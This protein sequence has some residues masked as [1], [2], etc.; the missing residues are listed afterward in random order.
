MPLTHPLY[1]NDTEIK[2]RFH[3]TEEQPV[4]IAIE[5]LDSEKGNWLSP[6]RLEVV[7]QATQ[8][9]ATTPGIQKVMS[10]S[11]IEAAMV[12]GK[13]LVVGNIF[14]LL[15]AA[16]WQERINTD[17]LLK[18]GLLS[19]DSRITA[20]IGEIKV[21]STEVAGVMIRSIRQAMASRFPKD[22]FRISVTGVVSLQADMTSLIEIEM[23]N[24]L[25]F[26][27]LTCF[28]T[29]IAYFRSFSSVVVCLILVVISNIGALSWMAIQGYSFSVLSTS[30]PILASITA[31]AIGSHTLLDFSANCSLISVKASVADKLK[32]LNSTYRAL[33]LPNFLMAI[34][35]VIGF[36][37]LAR[38]EIPLI[39]EFAW[40]V[41]GGILISWFLITV[42]LPPLL[43]LCPVPIS[44]SW[45]AKKAQ[46]IVPVL[47]YR[48]WILGCLIFIV[49]GLTWRGLP[50][51]WSVHLYDDL[52][53]YGEI[54]RSADL[55]DQRMGG[56]FPLEVLIEER[57]GPAP[58]NDPIR[59][60]AM[61]DALSRIRKL[62]GVGSAIGYADFFKFAGSKKLNRQSIAETAFLYSMT[63]TKDPLRQFL[64]SD[65]TAV[66]MSLRLQDISSD[67]MRNT[68]ESVN[69]IVRSSFPLAIVKLG[70][71]AT[72]AHQLNAELSRT[73]IMGLWESLF[74]IT[75]LI[76]VVFRSFRLA[77]VSALP[78]LMAPL[79][80]TAAMSFLQTPIKPIVGVIFSI[81][82]GL[83]YN[84]TVYLVV[85]LK[86]VNND[87]KR[88]WYEEGNPC[89]CSSMAMLGGFVVFL[90]SYFAINRSFG[91]YMLWS[92]TNGLLGDL[93][94]FPILLFIFPS[95]L[96]HSKI[97]IFLEN[98][99]RVLFRM[100]FQNKQMI[101]VPVKYF[102]LRKFFAEKE[103][104]P[105]IVRAR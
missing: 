67:K 89:L 25:A 13:D 77:L 88:A 58:W 38:S 102:Y 3:L 70:G 43:V 37:T 81:A 65:G 20:I 90:F 34:T 68:V 74:W 30:V 14:S 105:L 11:T 46:W 31:L 95:I 56:M 29:L 35:T 71:M 101:Q 17:P 52:P 94:L 12:Q 79:A 93:I 24:F 57:N 55:I 16:D 92:I 48:F 51:Q 61:D 21:T 9:V 78:N 8:L 87:V 100:V 62:P 98:K 69:R 97:F 75:L 83:A 1:A 23:R 5:L 2:K 86:N 59:L 19:E 49:S 50:L 63:G 7:K 36:I 41:S 64:T 39:E 99:A 82:L 27:F 91:G 66:R 10:L 53:M 47:K 6:E 33:L 76:I 84:N 60:G 15:P 85:R 54:K 26:A 44:R 28:L 42:T 104:D 32:I 45:T 72:M 40:S 18:P 103:H 73:L 80:L 96:N 22:H 4:L